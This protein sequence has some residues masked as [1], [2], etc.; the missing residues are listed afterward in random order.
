[1][2]KKLELN[3]HN[4]KYQQQQHYKNLKILFAD[5]LE[6]RKEQILT[7]QV[8]AIKDYRQFEEINTTFDQ[9]IANSLYD[10]PLMLEWNTWR[11]M[12]M[13]DGGILKLI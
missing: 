7:E 6:N 11:A 5:E 9:I 8:A 10:T 12:T 13:L 1:L 3:F 2:N 4:F